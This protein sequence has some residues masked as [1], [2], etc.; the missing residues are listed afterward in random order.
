MKRILATILDLYLSF[1]VLSGDMKTISWEPEKEEEE[2]EQPERE[3]RLPPTRQ[4]H[5][6]KRTGQR[7]LDR[8][9]L[10]G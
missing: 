5:E 7:G 4:A 10:I 8:G 2:D 3:D 9:L 1:L 6:S